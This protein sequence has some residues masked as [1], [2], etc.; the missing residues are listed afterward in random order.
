MKR[1]LTSALLTATGAATLAFAAL[2]FAALAIAGSVQGGAPFSC[3]PTFEARA[4][5]GNLDPETKTWIVDAARR[6]YQD[7]SRDFPAN[8]RAACADLRCASEADI[9]TKV[10]KQCTR[11][12][13][14]TLELA[15]QQSLRAIIA[16]AIGCD[17]RCA[18]R[19]GAQ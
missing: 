10:A 6:F 2:A 1:T 9:V 12:P 7:R 4:Q 14:Q 16:P 3:D 11:D 13:A 8:M 18:M 17:A 5:S 15:V 19:L